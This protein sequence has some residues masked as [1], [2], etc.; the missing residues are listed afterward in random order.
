MK[1]H[2]MAAFSSDLPDD[3]IEDEAGREIIQYG[4]RNVAEVMAQIFRDAGYVVGP[5]DDQLE[6]GWSFEAKRDGRRIWPLLQ[7]F[8]GFLM[9]Q[10]DEG[11]FI[12]HD[13]KLFKQASL[14]ILMDGLER[15]G[16]FHDLLWFD[17]MGEPFG[18]T[19]PVVDAPGSERRAAPA[20]WKW[21]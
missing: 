6:R 4:G 17:E 15:D 18:F 2:Q 21:T 5:L 9:L 20:A 19:D 12:S 16:R 13:Q 8:W 7:G 1:F 10:I 11:E 3:T 14:K